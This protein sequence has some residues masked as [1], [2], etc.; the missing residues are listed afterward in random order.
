MVSFRKPAIVCIGGSDSAAAAG[1]QADSRIAV[2]L[3]Y[4]A[5]NV[6]TA[7]TAQDTSAVVGWE[8]VSPALVALQWQAL[9]ADLD[10]AAIKVGMVG[11][12]AVAA[13]V[14][15]AL[16]DARCPVVVDPV[17]RAS[18]GGE[19]ATIACLDPLLSLATVVTPNADEAAALTGLA[20]RSPADA[21]LA[22]RN[23]LRAGARAV[24]IKGGH[25]SIDQGC[26]VLVAASRTQTFPANAFAAAVRGTGCSLASAIA[27][28]LADGMTL[29]D[30]VARA[31]AVIAHMATRPY[32]I[33]RGT[34]LLGP[35]P[36]RRTRLGRLHVITD[37]TLQSRWDHTEL[38]E[39]ALRG[40]ADTIQY[41]E[42]RPLPARERLR[43]AE[44]LMTLCE[45]YGATLV[46]NDDAA[47]ARAVG[48]ALHVGADDLPV[49]VARRVV[50]MAALV[51]A[52]ANNID[53]AQAA[54]QRA[55]DYVGVGPV[56]GT[57]SKAKSAPMLGT[58]GLRAICSIVTHPVIAIG[59]I[60][61]EH[62]GD[63][64]MAGAHG[65]AVLSGVSCAPDPQAATHAYAVAI[66]EALA[67]A[68]AITPEAPSPRGDTMTLCPP[69]NGVY[70][71]GKEAGEQL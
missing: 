33:G 32:A 34:S 14:A 1:L 31:R 63:V 4:H 24:L 13:V 19:L 28:G 50:G 58:E 62:I 52:T 56:F 16:R 36:T 26:D 41:R 68:S 18:N 55:V 35:G 9:S 44:Q 7:V 2:E 6:V 17:L 29:V 20:V 61:S 8:N 25:F 54:A 30:A 66:D 37:M 42:K 48:A 67:R 57:R 3:G 60:A 10:I 49:A 65:V 53:A 64:M 45:A 11:S 69:E 15:D 47:V 12:P 40:G 70:T 59:G 71:R 5:A 51:G 43:V 46:I 27:C 39:Q 22:G 23:L 21:E 38:A